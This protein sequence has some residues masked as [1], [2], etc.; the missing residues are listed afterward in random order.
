MNTTQP[1]GHIEMRATANLKV[2]PAVIGLPELA[3]TDE[4]FQAG[5]EDVRTNGVR[6]PLIVTSDGLIIDGRHR[7]RWAAAAGLDQVPCMVSAATTATEVIAI[8]VGTLIHRR[9]YTP[10]QIA[11][12]LYPSLRELHEAARAAATA[13]MTANA[14]RGAEKGSDFPEPLR[15]LGED[16]TTYGKQVDSI[17]A[18][19]ARLGISTDS[20]SRAARLFEIFELS[21]GLQLQ[22]QEDITDDAGL[23]EGKAYTARQV[24]WPRLMRRER[25]L[26]LGQAVA[27]LCGRPEIDELLNEAKRGKGKKGGRPEDDEV[28]VTGLRKQLELFSET[29]SKDIRTRGKYWSRFKPEERKTALSAIDEGLHD[30]PEDFLGALKKRVVAEIKRRKKVGGL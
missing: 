11:L 29:W 30:V 17:S 27:G 8:A 10:G 15:R 7:K 18:I 4:E 28:G 1:N 24:F 19:C 6:Q 13:K 9:H 22:W 2:H 26:G 23:E 14:G 20:F 16:S 25:P 12:V 3:D 5:R 21:D